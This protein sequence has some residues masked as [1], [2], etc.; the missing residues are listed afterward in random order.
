MNRLAAVEV[1]ADSP[2]ADR[3]ST[4]SLTL[5]QALNVGPV[6]L[7]ELLLTRGLYH[8]LSDRRPQAISWRRSPLPPA[9][10]RPT[11][12]VTPERS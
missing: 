11:P 10:S 7:S 4:E 2:D 9:A 6:Q 3:L 8:V 1:F 12:C 5:G